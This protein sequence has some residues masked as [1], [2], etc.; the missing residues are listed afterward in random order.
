MTPLMVLAL[1]LPPSLAYV[2]E[3]WMAGREAQARRLAEADTVKLD[4]I[5]L[6]QHGAAERAANIEAD[7]K[8]LSEQVSLLIDRYA[9]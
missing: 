9:R 5:T 7:V 6:Q 4:V 8:R 2:I 1:T 3:R